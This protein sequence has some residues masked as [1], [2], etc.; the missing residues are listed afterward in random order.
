MQLEPANDN[1][2]TTEKEGI[3]TNK[4]KSVTM[5]VLITTLLFAALSVNLFA[6]QDKKTLKIQ[7]QA[8]S[9]NIDQTTI[10]FDQS[11]LPGYN[12]QEDAQKIF[13]GVAGKPEL[14]SVTSDNI[15]CSNN[16]FGTL[17]NTETVAIGYDVDASGLFTITASQIDNFDP[18]SIIRLEDTQTGTFTDLRLGSVQVT[19]ND[20]DPLTGRFFIHVTRPAV[21]TSQNSGC[22]NNDGVVTADLDNSANWTLVNLYD[23]FNNPVGSYTSISGQFNFNALPEGDYHLVMAFG[24][25]TTTKD[26][27]VN[28]N[29]VVAD[30]DASAFSVETM[31]E[32]NFYSLATNSNQYEWDF[33]DGTLIIGVANPSLSYLTPG[34][35]TVNMKAS[36]QAGC[37]DNASVTV[38]VA[39]RASAIKDEV[40]EAA[41]VTAYGKTVKVNIAE[42]VSTGAQIE[43]FNLLGQPVHHSVV[44]Q[45]L[46]TVALDNQ[47][48]GYYLVAVKNGEAQSTKRIYAGN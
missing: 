47:P 22:L 41:T 8:Q 48:N 16:G 46:S 12:F 28:G 27:H 10:Y 45:Q 26:F 30:I 39:D 21:F 37:S 13:S 44:T 43:I 1:I 18:T 24:S 15:Q 32:I 25:Y 33:G 34:V 5:R 7:L 23:A 3:L 9:G 14:F 36:N 6:T 20:N 4:L 42:A 38:T 19:L 29:Y 40:K 35:Y 11:I 2:G 17:S 31:E